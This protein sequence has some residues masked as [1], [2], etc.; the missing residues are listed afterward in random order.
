MKPTIVAFDFDGTITTKDTLWEFI[1]KT[2]HPLKIAVN[3]IFMSPLL[4]LYK[5]GLLNNGKAKQA[6]FSGFY[7][8]WPIEKFNDFGVS[9]KST[10]DDCVRPEVY[11]TLKKHVTK[12]HKVIIVSASIENWILPWAEKEGV[13]TVIATRIEVGTQGKLTGRF[14]SPNCYGEEKVRRILEMFPERN[15]YTLI[16]YGDSKGDMAMLRLA[17][18]CYYLKNE[19]TNLPGAV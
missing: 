11:R 1:K 10:I 9:F 16:V 13:E 8:N 15:S 6:L 2:H 14:M 18:K 3:L 4:A 5:T 12:G 17:D 19:K 7:K